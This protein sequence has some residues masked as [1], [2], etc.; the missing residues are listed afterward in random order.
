MKLFDQ[1][2]KSLKW[3]LAFST[4]IVAIFIGLL[5][6][7]LPHVNCYGETTYK[8]LYT[9]HFDKVIVKGTTT[10]YGLNHTVEITTDTGKVF[11]CSN[12]VKLPQP[13][14]PNETYLLTEWQN[15]AIGNM[16]GYSTTVAIAYILDTKENTETLITS[17]QKDKQ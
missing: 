3:N 8:V 16:G 11:Y 2:H 17:M 14:D 6:L 12:N 1:M 5:F 15:V 10:R 4:L 13:F 9:G 7:I